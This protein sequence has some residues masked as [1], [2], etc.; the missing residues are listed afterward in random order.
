M[1]VGC[2]QKLKEPISLALNLIQSSLTE[3][4]SNKLDVIKQLASLDIQN[5]VDGTDNDAKKRERFIEEIKSCQ[6]GDYQC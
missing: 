1:L 3:L 2:D 4:N 6:Q 5:H